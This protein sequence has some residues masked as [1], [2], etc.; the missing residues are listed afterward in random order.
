MDL[1][2]S[3]NS[4]SIKIDNYDDL[5]IKAMRQIPIHKINIQH[6]RRDWTLQGH[7]LAFTRALDQHVYTGSN[8]TEDDG[9]DEPEDDGDDEPEDDEG[10][11]GSRT[12]RWESNPIGMS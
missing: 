4:L 1:H 11:G 5:N 10:R 12:R 2:I 7:Q 6:G 9:D 3:S 8:Y